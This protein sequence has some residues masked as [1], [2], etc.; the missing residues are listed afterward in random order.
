MDGSSGNPRGS[1]EHGRHHGQP[2]V[3]FLQ[4]ESETSDV[5]GYLQD[6]LD[7]VFSNLLSLYFPLVSVGQYST[8]NRQKRW[9]CV[10][11][12]SEC[13]GGYFRE[14]FA[15]LVGSYRA[16]TERAGMVISSER[17]KKRPSFNHLSQVRVGHDVQQG[18][19]GAD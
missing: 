5:R 18:R 12:L 19:H 7:I 6:Y 15:S 13:G 14:Q 2:P 4:D 3:H 1:P 10:A 16:R 9:L 8:A 11:H 17:G